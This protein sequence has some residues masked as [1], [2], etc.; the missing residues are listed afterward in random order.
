MGG[1]NTVADRAYG[2]AGAGEVELAVQVGE[3]M[4]SQWEA[5]QLDVHACS[6]ALEALCAAGKVTENG[7]PL[8]AVQPPSGGARGGRKLAGGAGTAGGG[9]R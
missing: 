5:L 6:L 1:G 8:A 7:A 3:F 2:P 9:P 4:L